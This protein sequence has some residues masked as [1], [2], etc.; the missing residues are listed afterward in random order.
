MEKVLLLRQEL[1]EQAVIQEIM[2]GL[3]IIA[4]IEIVYICLNLYFKK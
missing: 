2:F 1:A 3:L 4:C